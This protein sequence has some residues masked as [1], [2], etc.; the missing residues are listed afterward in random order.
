[1]SALKGK[2]N[3]ENRRSELS[4]CI[5]IGLQFFSLLMRLKIFFLLRSSRK[6]LGYCLF[7]ELN[8]LFPLEN[9]ETVSPQWRVFLSYLAKM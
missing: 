3:T 2:K 8:F 5:K 6:Y 1:M 4:N 9:F 7:D